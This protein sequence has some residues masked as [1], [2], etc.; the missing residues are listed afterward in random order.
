MS[1]R[2]A[3]LH[4]AVVSQERRLRMLEEC[5]SQRSAVNADRIARPADDGG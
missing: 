1:K 5:R 3:I 2:A 4:V